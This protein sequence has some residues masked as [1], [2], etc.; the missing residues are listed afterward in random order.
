MSPRSLDDEKERAHPHIMLANSGKTFFI[1]LVTS[2]FLAS[3]T[4]HHRR[5]RPYDTAP[6]TQRTC[7]ISLVLSGILTFSGLIGTV[8]LGTAL[9]NAAKADELSDFI[10]AGLVSTGVYGQA[11]ILTV[12]LVFATIITFCNESL[13]LAHT[14]SLRWA[15]WREG[16]LH[17]N[18]NLRL[19]TQARTSKPNHWIVNSYAILVTAMT[20]TAAGQVFI[21]NQFAS[22]SQPELDDL[23][24]SVTALAVMTFGLFS[25]T[26]ITTWSFLAMRHHAPTW[27]ANTLNNAL[28]C[29]HQ[30]LEHR[31]NRTL[32]SYNKFRNEMSAGFQPQIPQQRQP[33]LAASRP[34]AILVIILLW[35]G[36][37]ATLI[38][39]SCTFGYGKETGDVS[40]AAGA[41]VLHQGKAITWTSEESS[42]AQPRWTVV[43]IGIAFTFA[44]QLAFT[45]AL[46]C[47]ELLVNATRDERLWR[48][49]SGNLGGRLHSVQRDSDVSTSDPIRTQRK[50]KKKVN[51]AGIESN[52]IKDAFMAW[53]TVSLF[54]FKIIIPWA[55]GESVRVNY[56]RDGSVSIVLWANCLLLLLA[57]M[58]SVALLGTYL[59]FRR[60]SGPQ[61]VAYG[62]MQTLVDLVD[63]WGKE[64]EG[65]YWGDKGHITYSEDGEIRRAGTTGR[66][67]EVGPIR[68]EARYR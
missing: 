1:S 4:D 18:T 47:T 25:L 61:P 37:L 30:G 50:H 20:Y 31:P 34:Y 58:F 9:A 5:L 63:E 21:V 56:N 67:E 53:E 26:A 66:S 32:L 24:F 51:G 16:R 54:I 46:H 39:T 14:N 35:L 12:P 44:T 60:P 49:A 6:S 55:F 48:R 62:H 42:S 2:F 13:G 59:C 3:D 8:A 28:A 27:S 41:S 68:M 33:S 43:L 11:A 38:W 65:L 22:A 64:Y 17:F 40:Q 36:V 52:A 7:H 45:F 29:A 23:T 15:L 19:M 10:S 57:F